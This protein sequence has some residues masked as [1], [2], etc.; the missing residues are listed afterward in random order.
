MFHKPPR[1]EDNIHNIICGKG[2]KSFKNNK[3]LGP[4]SLKQLGLPVS[5]ILSLPLPLF[6][7]LIPWSIEAPCVHLSALVSKTWTG[8]RSESSL[9]QETKRA[10]VTSVNRANFLSQSFIG[11]LCKPR[12]IS[13][14]LS[15]IF[16]S[17]TF[18]PY[19]SLNQSPTLFFLQVPLDPAGTGPRQPRTVL[20]AWTPESRPGLSL[21][22]GGTQLRQTDSLKLSCPSKLTL[23]HLKSTWRPRSVRINACISL[24]FCGPQQNGHVVKTR[25]QLYLSLPLHCLVS[26]C[27]SALQKHSNKRFQYREQWSQTEDVES[28]GQTKVWALRVHPLLLGR[29]DWMLCLYSLCEVAQSCA[30][31]CDP[32]DCSPPGSS[33]HG[34]L[35]ARILEWI[36]ISFSRGSSQPRDR[37]QVSS[38]Q[39]DALCTV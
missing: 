3:A 36:S 38:L 25:S 7:R 14:F 6:F 20:P 33:H 32:V 30:T 15:S 31:L 34:I 35:Q 21:Q 16:L 22:Q 8:R 18:F 10:P 4:H 29:T 23:A 9:P 19:L 26:V 5:I 11:P 39:A 37:T 17:S 12:N 1:P 2:I 24:R 13:L 28:C 27:I